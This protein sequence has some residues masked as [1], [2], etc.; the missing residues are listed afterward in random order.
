L[1]KINP[2]DPSPTA[3]TT[4]LTIAMMN[5]PGDRYFADLDPVSGRIRNANALGLRLTNTSGAAVAT[6]RTGL[7][8]ADHQ[9]RFT[10]TNRFGGKINVTNSGEVTTGYAKYAA[11]WTN[12]YT[13]REGLIRGLSFGSTFAYRAADR[14]YYYTQIERDAA[15][16]V[17]G[18]RRAVF[19]LPDSA[20]IDLF[21]SYDWRIGPKL[22]W[23]VQVNANNAFNNYSV[24]VLPDATTGSPR[25]ARFTTQPRY[26]FLTTTLSF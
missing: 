24:V 4:Q 17:T 23:R 2:S 20:I 7:P 21:A 18:S 11:I 1:V 22:R 15:G 19:R 12:N 14:S 25:S 9:L 10:D 3:P 8:I 5:T 26:V 16:A 6:G 13:F